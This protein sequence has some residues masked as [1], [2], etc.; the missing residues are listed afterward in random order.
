[1]NRPT[2]PDSLDLQQQPPPPPPPQPQQQ[3]QQQQHTVKRSESNA[4][5]EGPPSSHGSSTLVSMG[6]PLASVSPESA[7]IAASA[8]TGIVTSNHADFLQGEGI[9]GV[10]RAPTILVTAPSLKLINQFL[11]FLLYSFLSTAKSTSLR[12]L[13]PA[14]EQVL[15][16]RL[17]KEAVAGADHELTSY[18]GG[19]D[20]EE[21]D[22][23]ELQGGAGVWDLE[24]TW[25]KTR[26]RC[27]V[28]SSLGDLE[29][30]DEAVY[31]GVD[32][33]GS[34]GDQ[35]YNP[36]SETLGVVSPPVAIWLTAVL[37]FVGEQTLLVAGHAAINRF[38]QKPHA[39]A[40]GSIDSCERP[41]V[42]ELDAEKVALNPSLG[43][44]W[45][46]WRKRVR[47]RSSF[48]IPAFQR[49]ER[50]ASN[51]SRASAS[52]FQPAENLPEARD[53]LQAS[54]ERVDKVQQ[55]ALEAGVD[56]TTTTIEEASEPA[57]LSPT[58]GD[59][60]QQ[61]GR[62][63]VEAKLLNSDDLMVC[64]FTFMPTPF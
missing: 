18:L 64:H 3:Q 61:A 8:A 50:R 44:L 53:T 48:S 57:S 28:Y 39:E 46:Q 1:M 63:N 52:S 51:S 25:K 10:G 24:A 36:H 33:E 20:G 32:L 38:T 19:G 11:D 54:A 5:I 40:A 12:A 9:T 17:A 13:R 56:T 59:T 43:R 2:R 21:D 22:F 29:E 27:M 6:C 62:S 15:R 4:S 37:E 14:V 26:L 47:G 31:S 16:S 60:P 45:R 30:E 49:H 58:V 7:Y 35:Q 34:V 55:A 41:M 23:E 42:E